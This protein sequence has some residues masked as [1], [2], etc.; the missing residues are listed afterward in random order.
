[1]V[2]KHL[3]AFYDLPNVNPKDVA[4]S[5]T[6]LV[7]GTKQH[8]HMLKRQLNVSFCEAALMHWLERRL[9]D[10]L[11]SKWQESLSMNHLPTSQQF[12]DFRS[13]IVFR[14]TSFQQASGSNQGQKRSGTHFPRPPIRA[15]SLVRD[16]FLQL[17]VTVLL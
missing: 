16:H 5:L 4:A 6:K 10:G 3:G 14:V 12:Y 9:P 17:L 11:K 13:Q 15:V 8:F 7:D 2:I 1:M